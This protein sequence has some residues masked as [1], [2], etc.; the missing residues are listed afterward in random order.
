MTPKQINIWNYLIK[1]SLGINNAINVSDLANA[2]G[3]PL[4]ARIMMMLEIG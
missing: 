1:N 2:V 4:K 3:I